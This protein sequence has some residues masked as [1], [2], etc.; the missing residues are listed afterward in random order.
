L[1]HNSEDDK[2]K[3]FT[4][5]VSC[6]DVL[7][8]PRA[9]NGMPHDIR[10]DFLRCFLKLTHH[11]ASSAPELFPVIPF[12]MII[13]EAG[14]FFVGQGETYLQLVSLAPNIGEIRRSS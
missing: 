2:S 4:M 5:L 10:L 1:D 7:Q 9:Q 8:N 12:Q 14:R 3:D 13:E 11:K 6:A